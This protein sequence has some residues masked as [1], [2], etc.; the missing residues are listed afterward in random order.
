ME[1][2]LAYLTSLSPAAIYLTLGGILLLCGLG[3]PIPEDI[4]LIAAGYLAYL[5]DVNVHVA[6]G[7]CLATVLAGDTMAFFAGRYFGVRILKNPHFCRLMTPRKQIRMRAYFRKYG[8]KVIFIG[9]FLPGLRTSLFFSAGIL[10]LRPTV[11]LVYDALAAALSVPA[12]VYGA[13]FFGERLDQVIH[14]ARRSEYGL[15]AVAAVVVTLV[16]VRRYRNKRRRACGAVKETAPA[17]PAPH[18][19]QSGTIE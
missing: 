13:W 7:V 19:V 1:A 6:L 5:G 16:L 17:P 2:L 9:R 15:L 18:R 4:S 8:S 14:W 10:K 3:L 12:L 11:F